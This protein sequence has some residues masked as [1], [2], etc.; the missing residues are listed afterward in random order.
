MSAPALGLPDV[1]K[2]FFLF[3]H[4]KQG[5]ALGVLAQDL[6][7]YQ[8]AVANF[9][10]QLDTAAKVWLGCLR[11]VAAAAVNIQ[12]ACKFTLGQK[13]TV[14]VSH[15]VSA[16]L[17]AKGGRWLSP[18]RFLKYQAILVEQNDVETVVTNI[19]NP[20]SFLSRSEGNQ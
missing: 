15:T 11:A 12:E 8:K 20:A 7:P 1:S 3:S 18:Q 4:E 16:V 10:K 2:P 5:I 19:V 14:L 6:R 13:L 17:K 9:S